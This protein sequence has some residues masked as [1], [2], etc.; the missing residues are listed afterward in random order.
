MTNTGRVQDY[1]LTYL[2]SINQKKIEQ[3]ETR[4]KKDSLKSFDTLSTRIETLLSS[5]EKTGTKKLDKDF[6]SAVK[7]LEKV[8]KSLQNIRVRSDS[9][10]R[11]ALHAL[12]YV[13]AN[14]D[15]KPTVNVAAPKVEVKER[16]IDF[17]PLLDKLNTPYKAPD[18][19]ADYKAQDI[20]E[21][22][23]NTQYIGFVNPTGRWYIIEN[24]MLDGSLRYKF[25]KSGYANA[26]ST[27]TKHNYRRLNEAFNEVSA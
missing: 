11:E 23:P 4:Y 8:S 25:G 10:I 13:L 15:I 7:G 19:L 17:K 6:V 9:E 16:D 5:L 26:W 12:A 1:N 18:T 24:N 2:D 14:L 20:I 22:D 3:S 21:T 27:P